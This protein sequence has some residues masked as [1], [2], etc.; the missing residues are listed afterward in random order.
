[1]F[2]IGFFVISY[3]IAKESGWQNLANK[4]VSNNYSEPN[5]K[6][7][8]TN[9][10]IGNFRYSGVLKILA[11]DDGL[12]LRVFFP[13][14]FGH[15]NLFI[16]WNEISS[17]SLEKS[18]FRNEYLNFKLYKFPN[19]RLEIKSFQEL[20]DNIPENFKIIVY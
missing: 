19:Q 20:L 13:F 3:K 5:K 12:Y 18:F 11:N 2:S 14:K 15:K 9:G 17:I 8:L 16:P 7:Y 6:F 1:M 10:Y 4:F